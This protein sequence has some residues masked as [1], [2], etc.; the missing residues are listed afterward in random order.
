M[1]FDSES[2]SKLKEVIAT[3]KKV[4]I[5]T[6]RNPDGDALSSSL[7]WKMF[8][9]KKGHEVNFRSPRAYTSNLSWIPGTSTTVECENSK[10]RKA[11]DGTIARA[12]LIFFLV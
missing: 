7:G 8:L 11:C 4:V 6:H 2:I 3:P 1:K 12:N 10:D 9:E 5:T